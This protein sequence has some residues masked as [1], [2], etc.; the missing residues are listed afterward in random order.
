MITRAADCRP[1]RVGVVIPCYNHARVLACALASVLGQTYTDWEAVVVDDGSTDD[2][3]AVAAQ[4]VDP[5]I[6]Y[7]Y[8]AN[9]GL[10]GARNTGIRS[11]NGEFLAFLDADD[12][13]DPLFM[14]TC[15]GVLAK[16]PDVDGV[17]TLARFI[18]EIGRVLPQIGGEVVPPNRFRHRLLK[19]GFF[20]PHAVLL[21]AAAVDKI[22]TFD[23]SLTS[24]EDWDFWLRLTA[25]DGVLLSVPQTLA[26]YRV[27]VESMSTNAAR[28]HTNRMA[29]LTKQFGAP[30][31]DPKA[32]SPEKRNAF[33]FAYRAAALGYF[34]QHE[35]D[36]GWHWLSRAAETDGEIITRLDTFYELALGD[37]PRGYRGEAKL[38]DL[39][40]REREL[41]LAMEKLFAS[42]SDDIRRL[43]CVAYG[44]L[45]LALAMLNDQAGNWTVARQ[46][47]LAAIRSNPRLAL[48]ASLLRRLAKLAIGQE[49]VHRLRGAQR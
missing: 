11:T 9:R 20:P 44:N 8:Q 34:A 39:Q 47:L 4:F 30:E 35:I 42:A 19:G 37:Q 28:M 40:L 6:H 43:R 31:G 45:F 36:I 10:S 1:P 26:R 7:V 13:W 25:A 46:Q 38:L 27:S 33:A 23:E 12:E 21:R 3:R 18:D 22:G 32:W 48:D 5:R 2:T 49:W 16:W 15:V 24:L 29:V 14:E 41:L 17:V